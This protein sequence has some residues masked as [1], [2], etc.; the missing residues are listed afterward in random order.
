MIENNVPKEDILLELEATNTGENI[1]NS[2]LLLKNTGLLPK[3]II[4]VQKTYMERRTFAAFIKQRPSADRL[5]TMVTSPKLEFID[6]VDGDQTSNEVIS[7][8][9]GDLQR[10]IEYSALGYQIYQD[11]PQRVQ[12]A[13]DFLIQ[14]GYTKHLLQQK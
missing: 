4:L 5:V 2:Y 1:K 14:H 10:I 6:Y 3:S 12:V 8:M 9:L 11:V 13:Y 7:I